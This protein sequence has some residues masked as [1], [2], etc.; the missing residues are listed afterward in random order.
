MTMIK[1]Y[2]INCTSNLIICASRLA[3]GRKENLR[4]GNTASN[5]LKDIF[6]VKHMD[7]DMPLA[8]N[9]FVLYQSRPD[10]LSVQS[11]HQAFFRDWKK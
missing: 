4:Q 7:R 10:W 9:F 8:M 11:P 6:A 3:W 1:G 2:V 5:S